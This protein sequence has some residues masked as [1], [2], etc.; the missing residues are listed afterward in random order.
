M[1]LELERDSAQIRLA[2]VETSNVPLLHRD[3]FHDRRHENWTVDGVTDDTALPVKV[4]GGS[5]K[6][7][8]QFVLCI[9]D[10]VLMVYMTNNS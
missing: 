6:I 9:D 8:R 3:Q 1:R 7:R 5:A 4:L 10:K 2:A